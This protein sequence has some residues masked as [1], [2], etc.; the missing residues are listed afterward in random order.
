VSDQESNP[1]GRPLAY[2][3][4]EELQA[5]I[6]L[7][8]ETDAFMVVGYNDSG[9]EI[10]QFAPTMSGLALSLGVDRRTITNYA[11]K[12]EFFPTI[13][14]ARAK[15][16]VALEQGLYGKNVTGLIFNLKN[17]FDWSDKQEIK[18]ETTHKMED[19]LAERLTGG[20]K[21]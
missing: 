11:S 9:I 10:K 6:D 3:T 18:Q 12:D 2:K 15:V 8:F 7:Y 5:A 14:K 21:R 4:A 19:S 17:N 1:V 13:K 20:S 16:E